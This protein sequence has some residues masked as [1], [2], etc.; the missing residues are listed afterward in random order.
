VEIRAFGRDVGL[1]GY[2]DPSEAKHLAEFGGVPGL[3]LDLGSGGGWPGQE[4]IVRSG[5]SVVGMDMVLSG[6]QIAR[7]RVADTDIADRFHFVA[8]DGQ[9]LPFAPETFGTVLHADALC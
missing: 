6:L 7:Q 4:I 8:G 1:N 9:R 2:T 3:V 5:R